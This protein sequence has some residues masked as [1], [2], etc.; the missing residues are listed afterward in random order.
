[1]ITK[2]VGSANMDTQSWNFSR[3]VNLVVDSSEVAGGWDA[4]AFQPSFGRAIVVDQ[5]RQVP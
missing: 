4:Q 3:E 1:M 5:C 2:I